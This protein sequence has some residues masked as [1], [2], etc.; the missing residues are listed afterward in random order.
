MDRS[1]S[2]QI[3]LEFGTRDACSG[4]GGGLTLYLSIY[5]SK[6]M[7]A[8]VCVLYIWIDLY[9]Y[10]FTLSLELATRAAAAA[11]C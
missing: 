8:Q 9:L 4:D 6:Q 11:A 1:S 10:M 3:D 5:I 2:T 7:D